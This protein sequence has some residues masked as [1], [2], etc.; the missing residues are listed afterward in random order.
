MIALPFDFLHAYAGTVDRGEE[1]GRAPVRLGSGR[2]ENFAVA[3]D[4]LRLQKRRLV[5]EIV[6]H[7]VVARDLDCD[8]VDA[9]AEIFA[10][11]PFVDAEPASRTARGAVAR[12]FAVDIDAHNGRAGRAEN[13]AVER[14]AVGER[15]FRGKP[16]RYVH[17]LFAV[18]CPD[19]LS[20]AKGIRRF[21]L[22]R[23]RVERDRQG[24]GQERGAA[25]QGGRFHKRA[26]CLRHDRFL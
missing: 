21:A 23:V 7:A 18:L 9:G 3:V 26:A 1:D 10:D 8:F 13:C 22:L 25:E 5:E 4:E 2:G 16:Q 12:V 14:G 24:G 17:F 6:A 15:N 19:G 11:L 20:G